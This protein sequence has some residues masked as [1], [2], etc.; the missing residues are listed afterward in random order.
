MILSI[1]IQLAPLS[2]ELKNRNNVLIMLAR[3][4]FFTYIYMY[5]FPS[6]S[7]RISI[8][9]H[10]SS[11]SVTPIVKWRQDRRSLVLIRTRLKGLFLYGKQLTEARFQVCQNVI[12]QKRRGFKK[13]IIRDIGAKEIEKSPLRRDKSQGEI[14]CNR[15][16]YHLQ[17]NY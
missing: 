15:F 5:S 10:K 4:D 11:V 14:T 17:V 8:N 12:Y 13:K 6:M 3:N 2:S 9:L 16:Q 1:T 7:Q